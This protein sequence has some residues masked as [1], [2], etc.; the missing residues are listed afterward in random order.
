[1]TNLKSIV[2]FRGGFQ[3]SAPAQVG[4]ARRKVSRL[5]SRGR[6][7]GGC[8]SSAVV[9]CYPQPST[10]LDPAV[11]TGMGMIDSIRTSRCVSVS[12]CSS[13]RGA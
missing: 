9:L 13:P 8:A 4:T 5:A 10:K 7:V 2:A 11:T 3:H 6:M 12:G 1:M